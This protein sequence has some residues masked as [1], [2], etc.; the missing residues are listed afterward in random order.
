MKK[1]VTRKRPS[2]KATAL[3]APPISMLGGSGIIG[4]SGYSGANRSDKR[5]Y[6]WWPTEATR[7]ELPQYTRRELVAKARWLDANV[8]LAGRCISGLANL[9]GSLTPFA[10]TA[11][12][13]WNELATENFMERAGSSVV[14][15][16]ASKLN[17]WTAQI[18]LLKASFRDGD[19]L[20]VLTDTQSGGARFAFYEAD[21][22][23]NPETDDQAWRDGVR[24]DRM[25]R[26]AAYA[27]V[28]PYDEAKAVTVA[29]RD[30]IYFANQEKFG[31][32]RGLT[33]LHRAINHVLDITEINSDVK[34]AIKSAA[35]VALVRSRNKGQSPGARGL[36]GITGTLTTPTGTTSSVERVATEDVWRGGQIAELNEGEDL[37]VMHDDRPH[38]NQENFKDSLI[39]DIS[40]GVGL[41]PSILWNIASMTS[42]GVRFTMAEAQRWIYRQH[43][44]LEDWCRRVWVYHIAK[45]LKAG[46]L[47][48][49]SDEKWWKV[50]FIGEPD[51]TIDRGREG[52]LQM[53]LLG[54]GMNTLADYYGSS[55]WH[56]KNRVKQRVV[57]V[58]E[59]K[60]LCAES[61]VE[62]HEVFPMLASK[63]AAGAPD[64]EDDTEEPEPEDDQETANDK[65]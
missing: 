21:Q 7:K 31:H 62:Y 43:E 22:I 65:S 3:P 40:W 18:H 39:R 30:C 58:A 37:K 56:W 52:K 55:G 13:R 63:G 10:N 49:C 53:D 41:S 23:R 33:V 29:A 14:F 5:G 44:R 57:E 27:V 32:V 15:D 50:D 8:G 59:A 47:P 25:G 28:D 60:K 4:S 61:G 11:D 26:H 46:R 2:A 16:R 19:V 35:A 45:E 34:H 51:M 1:T 20:T 6:V 42:A 24:V 64:E 36:S 38:P 54:H 12:E 17:Y 9:V 48:S